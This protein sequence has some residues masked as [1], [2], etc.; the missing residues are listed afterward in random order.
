M[1]NVGEIYLDDPATVNQAVGAFEVAVRTELS[2][3][4]VMHALGQVHHEG[5]FEPRVQFD[6]FVSQH[7]LHETQSLAKNTIK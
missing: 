4:D 3:L 1:V 6:P 5:Q 7:I 2:V